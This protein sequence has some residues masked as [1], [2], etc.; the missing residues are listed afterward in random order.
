MA[1]HRTVLNLFA[2]FSNFFSRGPIPAPP[3]TAVATT[4]EPP[5]GTGI[6]VSG[7]PPVPEHPPRLRWTPGGLLDNEGF[8][9][10]VRAQ[11]E[12]TVNAEVP[13]AYKLPAMKLPK[14]HKAAFTSAQLFA[15][16]RDLTKF[17]YG[18][19]MVLDALHATI[20]QCLGTATPLPEF[21]FTMNFS[22][23][24]SPDRKVFVANMRYPLQGTVELVQSLDQNM[25]S[26]WQLVVRNQLYT[27]TPTGP[28]LNPELVRVVQ[29][30]PLPA[31]I[32]DDTTDNRAGRVIDFD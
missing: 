1:V 7:G 31:V 29:P 23:A 14:S 17:D 4:V 32:Q 5:P 10:A 12:A 13:T 27:Y 15:Q 19:Q 18:L 16:Q 28:N 3:A 21:D 26:T 30:P 25:Q 11:Q 22:G 2:T 9:E 8:F 24:T 6:A 20:N